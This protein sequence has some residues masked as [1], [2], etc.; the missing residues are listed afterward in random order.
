MWGDEGV[1][2]CPVLSHSSYRH[3]VFY[4]KVRPKIVSGE[5]ILHTSKV[6]ALYRLGFPLRFST[7]FSSGLDTFNIDQT[8]YA[9]NIQ[10]LR[11]KRKNLKCCLQQD[12]TFRD[13]MVISTWHLR[14]LSWNVISWQLL[15]AS[16]SSSIFTL[17]S[18]GVRLNWNMFE[19]YR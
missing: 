11:G 18:L 4:W 14:R 12:L 10:S 1:W 3:Y 9:L 6:V 8:H 19:F 13:V 2:K 5:A 15:D 17:R 7:W 16:L